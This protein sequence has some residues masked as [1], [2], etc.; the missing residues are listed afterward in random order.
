M[1]KKRGWF[2]LCKHCIKVLILQTCFKLVS[3]FILVTTHYFVSR[4][5]SA[6]SVAILFESY[7]VHFLVCLQQWLLEPSVK[8]DFCLHLATLCDCVITW[9]FSLFLLATGML[10]VFLMK[11]LNSWILMQCF[12]VWLNLSE[13][14]QQTLVRFPVQTFNSKLDSEPLRNINLWLRLKNKPQGEICISPRHLH[15]SYLD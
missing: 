14:S 7:S 15:R 10:S 6:A 3:I 9:L 2:L 13:V 5:S 4:L 11:S 12:T 1:V 8:S